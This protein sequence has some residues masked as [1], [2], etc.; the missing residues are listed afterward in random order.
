MISILFILVTFPHVLRRETCTE[1]TFASMQL[2]SIVFLDVFSKETRLLHLPPV[3]VRVN[4]ALRGWM[5]VAS[6]FYLLTYKGLLLRALRLH[7]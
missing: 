3:L 4:H 2:A 7:F 6:R 1:K 5:P